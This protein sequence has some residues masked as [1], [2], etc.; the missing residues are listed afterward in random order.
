MGVLCGN[1]GITKSSDGVFVR[2][3]SSFG[4]DC[5]GVIVGEDAIAQGREADVRSFDVF[6]VVKDD[7]RCRPAPR[8]L[9]QAVAGASLCLPALRERSDRPNRQFSVAAL[10][11]SLHRKVCIACLH[12]P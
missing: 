5:R 8:K 1:F 9:T 3:R 10:Q 11:A 4:R 12:K 6:G 7:H 2:A